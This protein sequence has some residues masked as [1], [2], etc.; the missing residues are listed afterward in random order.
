MQDVSDLVNL[1]RYPLTDLATPAAQRI[2][3]DGRAQLADNGLCLLPD[4]LTPL[5]L[6]A[7]AHEARRLHA[8][9]HYEELA[10]TDDGSGR[11]RGFPLPRLS[12]TASAAV[13]YDQIGAASRIRRLYQWDG[14]ASFFREL[15]GVARLYRCADPIIS[16][17]LMYYGDG[18]ELGWHFDPNNGVATLLLQA[19]NEGGVFEFVP[20]IRRDDAEGLAAVARVMDGAHEAVITAQLHPSTLALFQGVDSLHRVTRVKGAVPRII[21]TMSFDTEPGTMFSA[22]IRRRYS[23]R[24]A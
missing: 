21:L 20:K 24:T 6:D 17:L 4:F 12:R 15:L 19:A 3:A 13:A 22:E 23:G 14:L 16:C 11:L 8:D 9:A 10:K 5:A 7:M 18:D 2:I 1:A